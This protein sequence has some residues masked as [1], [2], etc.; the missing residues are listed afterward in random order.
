MSMKIRI[1]LEVTNEVRRAYR[2]NEGRSGLATR[3]EMIAHIDI[4]LGRR[5]EIE[6]SNAK[7]DGLMK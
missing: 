4:A 5:F 2:A 7:L 3:E 6:V 1:T